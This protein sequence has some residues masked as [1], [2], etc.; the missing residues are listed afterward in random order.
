[1]SLAEHHACVALYLQHD[2][3]VGE[4]GTSQV[5]DLLISM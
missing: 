3:D 4:A 2:A 5:G 1:M